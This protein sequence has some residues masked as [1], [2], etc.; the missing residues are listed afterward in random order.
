MGLSVGVEGMAR[1]EEAIIGRIDSRPSLAAISVP[2]L[3][4]IGDGDPL[5]PREQAEE[6]AAAIASARLVVVPACGHASTLEQPDAVN[7]ALLEWIES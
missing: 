3:V 7:R 4:L 2:T 6:I 1:Q 5:I